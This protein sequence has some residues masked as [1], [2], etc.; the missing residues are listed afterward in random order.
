MRVIL[1]TLLAWIVCAAGFAAP[2]A[3]PR[4]NVLLVVSDDQRPDT[5][6]AL[7]NPAIA[8]PQLDSLVRGGTVFVRAVSP[9]P[10]CVP[11]RAE[12]MTGVCGLRA[13]GIDVRLEGKPLWAESMRAAG[14]RTW[15]VGKWHN[16]GRPTTRGYEETHGLYTAGRGRRS[17]TCPLDHYGRPVTGYVGWM[18]QDDQGR[19]A[20]ERGVGLTPGISA[21]MADAAIALLRSPSDRPFFL[22]VNFTAPHDPLLIPPGWERKYD[23]AMIPLPASFRPEHGFDHGNGAGRDER[24][25]G[26]PRTADEVRRELA[27]YY[28]V[29]SHMDQQL[30]R[31]LAALAETGQADRTL[32][33]FAGDQ[34]LAIGSHGLRGKQNMYEHT[35][36]TP[37]VLRGPGIPRGRRSAAQCYLRDLFPTVCEMVGAPVPASVEGKSLLPVLRG[38]AEQVYS[39]VYGY[40]GDV[41]RMI[42][43]ERYKL[44]HYPQLNRDQLFDLAQ[45]PHELADLAGRAE[46]AQ[47]RNELRLELDRWLRERKETQP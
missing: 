37:L 44:I 23:P 41:Q 29:I 17:L 45:D 6:G 36:G 16:D 14:Y 40:F 42:R 25:F 28:A 7:G 38:T 1:P 8:T 22:H 26:H 46:Y 47:R 11:A 33:I 30:G 3:P 24:L 43:T 21:T 15:Y 5:I 18:F 32:V 10:L 39:C 34:G 2:N 9:N 31:I 12:M 4:P 27:A 20:P 35:I 19:F 13:S